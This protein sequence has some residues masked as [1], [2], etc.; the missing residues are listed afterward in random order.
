MNSLPSMF[1]TSPGKLAHLLN[2]VSLP[3][4]GAVVLASLLAFAVV[5]LRRRVW[6]KPA[7]CATRSRNQWWATT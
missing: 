5:A 2:Q 1:P 4:P 3:E 7:T 6:F